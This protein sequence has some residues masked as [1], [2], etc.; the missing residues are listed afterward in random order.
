MR[1]VLVVL[2]SIVLI[3]A[4]A[5]P[6]S[7]ADVK[8]SGS[9]VAQGYYDN[10]RALLANGGASVSNMWQRLQGADGLQGSGRPDADDPVRCPGK[11]MGCFRAFNNPDL[12]Q[13]CR[14]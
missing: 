11:D 1:K 3:M 5:L 12:N 2:L 6:V 9:Y 8:F 14:Q 4:F 13:S 10:N 7:A